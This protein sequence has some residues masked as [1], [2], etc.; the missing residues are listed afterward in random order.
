MNFSIIRDNKN[1]I[2]VLVLVFII[3]LYFINCYIKYYVNKELTNIKKVLDQLF[4]I[5][6]TPLSTPTKVNSSSDTTFPSID[7][8]NNTSNKDT[9]NTSSKETP[10]KP[11]NDID[12]YCD[13][14]KA[15]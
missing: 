7:T 14:T 3:V 15:S 13:P 5:N 10:S 12:S 8:P 11:D 4:E 6:V 1:Y 2:L 9:L